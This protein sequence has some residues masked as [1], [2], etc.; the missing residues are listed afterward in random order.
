LQGSAHGVVPT[1]EIFQGPFPV[2]VEFEE[3]DTPES[4]RHWPGG[5]ELAKKLQVWKVQNKEFPA[6]DPGLVSDPYGFDDSPDAEVISS[7]INSKGPEAVALGRH[8]NFFLWGFSAQPSD[9]TVSGRNCFLN[10]ICYI[11]KFDGQPP[12]VRKTSSGR[13][14]ALV[15]AGYAKSY[16]DQEFV[17]RLFPKA[18]RDEFGTDSDKYLRYYQDNLEYLHPGES[19][20]EVDEEVK[21]LGLSNRKVELLDRCVKMLTEGDHAPLARSILRR[22]TNED[23]SQSDEWHAWLE[24]NRDRLFFTDTGGYKFMVN[25][26]RKQPAAETTSRTGGR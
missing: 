15:Y 13:R 7:G 8:G 14:W 6:I 4:Y 18:L 16:G 21:E 24:Q 23:F 10:S 17:K 19:G 1:H 2:N 11:K 25:P 22:Y 12:L 5:A 20:F 3:A 9:M 26:I